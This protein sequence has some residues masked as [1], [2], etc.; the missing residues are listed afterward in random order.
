MASAVTVSSASLLV[1][2]REQPPIQPQHVET[3]II[4]LGSEA[5]DL[6]NDT[7]V[8]PV[9]ENGGELSA[10]VTPLSSLTPLAPPSVEDASRPESSSCPVDVPPAPLP[11]SKTQAPLPQPQPTSASVSMSGL[12]RDM[13]SSACDY[14][15]LRARMQRQEWRQFFERMEPSDYAQIVAK[16]RHID[17]EVA[18]GELAVLLRPGFRCAHAGAALRAIRN[19]NRRAMAQRL[20]PLCSD[21][22]EPHSH[23]LILRQLKRS[24]QA[25]IR[26]DL[27]QAI[28]TSR[29][30]HTGRTQAPQEPLPA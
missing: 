13:E 8:N 5:F 29:R 30:R 6:E 26:S 27:D 3:P 22:A 24:D 17:P 1:G 14:D 23:G 12:L 20:I 21:I 9:Y 15:L 19:N 4:V 2:L 28:A 25:A 11:P 18:A 10:D 7:T 16:V